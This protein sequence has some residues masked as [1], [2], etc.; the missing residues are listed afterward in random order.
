MLRFDR[1][2]CFSWKRSFMDDWL[3]FL[4]SR[5][6]EHQREIQN[7]YKKRKRKCIKKNRGTLN[8]TGIECKFC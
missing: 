5:Y 1:G 6:G 4:F 8:A 2:I 3:R 7:I